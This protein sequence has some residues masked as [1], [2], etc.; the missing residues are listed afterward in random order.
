MGFTIEHKKAETLSEQEIK[1]IVEIA[2]MAFDG[3]YEQSI[4]EDLDDG[5]EVLLLKKSGEY[6]SGFNTFE[7]IKTELNGITLYASY[8]IDFAVERN[9]TRAVYAFLSSM[10]TFFLR[11]QEKCASRFFIFMPIASYHMYRCL[12]GLYLNYYPNHKCE[13]PPFEKQLIDT[14]A[15]QLFGEHYDPASGLVTQPSNKYR[16]RTDIETFTEK[17]LKIPEIAFYKKLNPR[18]LDGGVELVCLSESIRSNVALDFSG[19]NT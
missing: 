8:I 4:R 6:I 10:V 19:E 2:G 16:V 14:F 13:T 15:A 9:N 17:E 5:V 11:E 7:L 18:S 12:S 1:R 3:D